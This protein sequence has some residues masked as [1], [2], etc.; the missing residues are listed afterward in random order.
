MRQR[1]TKDLL[2]ASVCFV[3]LAADKPKETDVQAELKKLHGTWRLVK[4]TEDGK[5]MPAEEAKKAKLTFDQTGNWKVQVDGKVIGAGT[6]VLDP[7][8]KPKTI[9]YTFTEG[10][11]KGTKFW[12]IYELDR[13]SFK[14]CG[15]L[16]GA[17]PTEFTA[18]AG[19]GRTLTMFKRETE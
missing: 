11:A 13:D 10:E 19:S 4:E 7:G 3:I 2:L 15:V 1:S 9:D 14:H 18:K 5:E 17:R 16:K 12:A 8:K 6:A